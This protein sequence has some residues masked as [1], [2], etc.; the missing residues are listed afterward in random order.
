MC[1]QRKKRGGSKAAQ[2]PRVLL[3]R[4]VEACWKEMGVWGVSLPVGEGG[5]G[6]PVSGQGLL[7]QEDRR[8]GAG[9]L[10]AAFIRPRPVGQIQS[11]ALQ[12]VVGAWCL[13]EPREVPAAPATP[14]VRWVGG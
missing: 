5:S 8:A 3:L 9:G 2:I 4:G 12:Q 6:P 13:P 10:E 11:S 14:R 1:G 7:R